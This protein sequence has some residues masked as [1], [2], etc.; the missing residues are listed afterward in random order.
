[1]TGEWLPED[2]EVQSVEAL[3]EHLVDEDRDTFTAE[4]LGHLHTNTGK[5]VRTLRFELEDWGF[6][7][8]KRAKPHRVRGFTTSS[9][10]RWYGPG[11]SP[12]HGGSGYEQINGFAGRQG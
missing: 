6:T 3:V 8:A 10:D 7:I 12:S 11:S 5:P 4:E 2:P 9:H 1:M